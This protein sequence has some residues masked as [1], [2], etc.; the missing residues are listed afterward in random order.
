MQKT[1]ITNGK[2]V[3]PKG[4]IIRNKNIVIENG[5]ITGI[6]SKRNV[7]KENNNII[8]VNG[9][10]VSPG[11]IDTHVHGAK[12]FTFME[13]KESEYKKILNFFLSKGLT[14]ILP[15]TVTLP[16]K[17]YISTMKRMSKVIKNLPEYFKKIILGF[18]IEGPFI[19]S[20][21]RGAQNTEGIIKKYDEKVMEK[22][23][24]AADDNIKIV[25]M[26]PEL[27][28][29]LN[30]I[31]FL[32]N[33][34]ILASAG[35]TDAK[36]NEVYNAYKTGLIHMSHTFNGMKGFHHR[37][38][39]VVGAA[40]LID[41]IFCELTLDGLHVVPEAAKILKKIKGIN[42]IILETDSSGFAG[43]E[44]GIYDRADGQSVKVDEDSVRLISNGSIAGSKLTM[45]LA[46]KNALEF[47]DCTLGEAVQMASYNPA[48][49]L[50]LHNRKGS[51]EINKD[52]DIVVFNENINVLLTMVEGEIL[53]REEKII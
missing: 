48:Y 29:S 15:T 7:I 6:T 52:A 32:N 5:V 42:K 27:E 12:G 45:D 2:I 16:T 17:K 10:Y 9:N 18:H 1:V 26:A 25:T 20:N 41:D 36:Y 8:D 3:V 47:L 38:P 19:N 40:F 44:P 34:D 37:E 30:L 14:G 11:F 39:G 23:I 35:H 50:G 31:E 53:Y 43:V 51:I 22:L 13:G 28:G 33:K 49:I 24:D 46:V 4:K 21:K